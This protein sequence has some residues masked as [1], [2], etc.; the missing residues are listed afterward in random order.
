MTRRFFQLLLFVLLFSCQ[1]EPQR[2]STLPEEVQSTRVIERTI[3]GKQVYG[4]EIKFYSQEKADRS[5]QI[6][7][8]RGSEVWY[9]TLIVDIP[10]RD[11][12]LSRITFSNCPVNGQGIPTFS[13]KEIIE[14]P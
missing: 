10:F 5:Y 3:G 12:L 2:I 8:T 7:A 14:R 13:V 4:L 9:D 1:R 6:R 11:T